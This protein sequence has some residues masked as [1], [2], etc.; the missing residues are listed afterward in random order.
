[1][2][3]EHV[4]AWGSAIRTFSFLGLNFL[5]LIGLACTISF[6]F[7]QVGMWLEYLWNDVI[8][9]ALGLNADLRK[10]G[11]WAGKADK[12]NYLSLCVAPLI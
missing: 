5:E 8:A 1:M 9:R 2:Q 12:F 7:V 11:E 10:L 3:I 6:I 4:I